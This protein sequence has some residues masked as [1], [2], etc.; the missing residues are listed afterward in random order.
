MKK[1][2]AMFTLLAG[3]LCLCGYQAL[4]Q[5]Q[6]TA[7]PVSRVLL[8]KVK[9]GRFDAFMEDLRNNARPIYDEEKQ[10]GLINEYHIYLNTT[11]SSPSDWDVAITFQYKNMAALDGLAEKL[12]ALTLK[13]YGSKESRQQVVEKR[14][15]N[16]ELVASHLIREIS[17]K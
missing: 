17:L 3:S 13:R 11:S 14:V 9:P 15:E 1:Q 7:G 6:Y 8:L 2:V 16:A 10:Q 5:L 4:A 12:D